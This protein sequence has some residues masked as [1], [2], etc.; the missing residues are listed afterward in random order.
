MCV[1]TV[2]IKPCEN[3]L[4]RKSNVVDSILSVHSWAAYSSSPNAGYTANKSHLLNK[5]EIRISIANPTVVR[6]VSEGEG[7]T[8]FL[9]G[10]KALESFPLTR[11]RG[12]LEYFLLN[13]EIRKSV[14][15]LIDTNVRMRGNAKLRV[16]IPIRCC[17]QFSCVRGIIIKVRA[18]A[19]R[20]ARSI[21]V[22]EEKIPPPPQMKDMTWNLYCRK[23]FQTDFLP[24]SRT[25]GFF[26][27]IFLDLFFII[28]VTAF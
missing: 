26:R 7:L 19:C 2:G 11:R 10:Q 24:K 20:C 1:F 25:K 4:D 17:T 21:T 5:R 14:L 6:V 28:F 27:A 18:H 9:S 3:W 13:G 12:E 15:C 23:Y 8:A 16:R 22:V